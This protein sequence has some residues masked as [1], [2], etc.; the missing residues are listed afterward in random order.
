[1]LISRLARRNYVTVCIFASL[2]CAFVFLG[3]KTYA[4]N[5]DHKRMQRQASLAAELKFMSDGSERIKDNFAYFFAGVIE[6][7]SQGLPPDREIRRELTVASSIIRTEVAI[8]SEYDEQ[9]SE[10][11]KEMVSHLSE[12]NGNIMNFSRSEIREYKEQLVLAKEGYETFVIEL[13][14]ATKARLQSSLD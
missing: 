13:N 1:M 7:I 6:V 8:L 10:R 12:L 5:I 11:G 3:M 4:G 2:I 14:D 9:L